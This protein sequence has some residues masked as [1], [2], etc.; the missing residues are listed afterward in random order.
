MI[1]PITSWKEVPGCGTGKGDPGE[2]QKSSGIEEVAEVGSQSDWS[3]KD[4]IPES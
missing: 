3:S 2:A 4:R 1:V